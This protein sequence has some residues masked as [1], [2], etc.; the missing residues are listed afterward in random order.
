M[1]AI[2]FKFLFGIVLVIT[3]LCRMRVSVTSTLCI[4]MKCFSLQW[5]K[6]IEV[7]GLSK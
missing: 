6:H 1:S 5:S 3:N 4:V 2:F 7:S